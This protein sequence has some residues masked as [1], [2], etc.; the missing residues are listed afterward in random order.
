MAHKSVLYFHRLIICIK[1]TLT[2]SELA[3]GAEWVRQRHTQKQQRHTG[4]KIKRKRIY[5]KKKETTKKYQNRRKNC[6]RLR[7]ACN[8]MTTVYSSPSYD[9]FFYFVHIRWPCVRVCV[10]AVTNNFCFFSV[11]LVPILTALNVICTSVR[12]IVCVHCR[13]C[14]LHLL[15]CVSGTKMRAYM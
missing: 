10:C 9:V 7:S 5:V 13:L 3:V 12:V 4:T 8:C 6:V 15:R 14:L 2:K 1:C 11:V